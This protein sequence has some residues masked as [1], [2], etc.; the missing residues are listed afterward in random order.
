MPNCWNG[1]RLST[2]SG[3][4]YDTGEGELG[5]STARSRPGSG[6]GEERMGDVSAF[7]K[8]F[9]QR[10]S[11]VNKQSGR[12]GTLWANASPVCW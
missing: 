9:K 5:E 12:F 6:V 1:C 7:M 11:R 8:E 10:F 4:S 3:E 2:G